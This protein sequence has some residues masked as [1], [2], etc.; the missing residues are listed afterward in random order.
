MK[1]LK[2]I[3]ET[4]VPKSSRKSNEYNDLVIRIQSLPS[5]KVLPVEFDSVAQRN[6][7]RLSILRRDQNIKC[8][9]VGLIIYFSNS[10]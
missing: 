10:K 2:T 3:A 6:S 8:S 7:A 4:N 1:I 5:G 9:T